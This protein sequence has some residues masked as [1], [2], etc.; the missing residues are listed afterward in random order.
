MLNGFSVALQ[1]VKEELTRSIGDN[2]VTKDLLDIVSY[3]C[4]PFPEMRGHPKT[5]LVKQSV[6]NG[7]PYDLERVVSAFDLLQFRARFLSR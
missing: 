3:L 2:I 6:T 1:I 4:Y 5:N 7:N